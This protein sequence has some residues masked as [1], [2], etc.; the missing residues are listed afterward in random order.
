MDTP[1]WTSYVDQFDLQS[2][3]FQEIPKNTNKYCVIV[4]PRS[5]PRL[6]PVIKNFMYL[7]QKKGWGLILFHGIENERFLRDGLSGW[8]NVRYIKMS[9]YNLTSREYSNIL[10]GIDF[11]KLLI[12]LGC[13]YA[14]IFQID[15]VLLKD[16]IDDFLKYDYIGAPWVVR[17]L[18][19]DIGNGGLSLRNVQ[20]M[21]DIV[22]QCSRTASTPFGIKY[23]ENEDI[24]FSFYLNTDTTA[25]LPSVETGK[26]FSVETIYHDDTCGMH[27]PHI[28]KFPNYDAFVA[29]LSKRYIIAS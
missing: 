6:I 5:H 3:Y 16:N 18:N 20:K 21:F 8:P 14:L 10:C 27:Q 22:N 1:E 28:G 2:S 24:Y 13:H 25:K 12:Q 9:V 17:W 29:L 4:E 19:M 7:L 26:Q 11:W 23:L 15:T